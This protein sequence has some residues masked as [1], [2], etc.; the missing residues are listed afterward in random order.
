MRTTK[1]SLLK[2]TVSTLSAQSSAE[3]GHAA[4]V[5]EWIVHRLSRK[6]SSG[7]YIPEVDG[8]RFLAI[9]SVILFHTVA[10]VYVVRGTYA[11]G[12]TEGHGLLIHLIGCGWFGVEI[13]F[14]LSG[15]IVALPFARRAVEGDG[16]PDLGRY[17]LRRV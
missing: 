1:M 11:P 7:E 10:M 14:V 17:F 8:I 5:S 4:G 12:W 9:M 16:R 6:T 2:A 15:F 13:F 3:A